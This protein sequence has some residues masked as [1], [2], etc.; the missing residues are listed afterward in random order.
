M[1]GAVQVGSALLGLRTEPDHLVCASGAAAKLGLQGR[2]VSKIILHRDWQRCSSKE[3]LL[4]C[5]WRGA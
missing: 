2:Q 1:G 4:R 3:D 5:V